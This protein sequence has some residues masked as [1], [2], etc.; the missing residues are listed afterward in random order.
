MI[1]YHNKARSLVLS[2]LLLPVL[3]AVCGI[4]EPGIMRGG[5]ASAQAVSDRVFVL[6][7]SALDIINAL[8]FGSHVVGVI[9]GRSISD[10]VYL[11]DFYDSHRVAVLELHGG[12]GTGIEIINTGGGV[13]ASANTTITN[14]VIIG[15][16]EG[17][18]D[19][20]IVRA[21]VNLDGGGNRFG[22]VAGGGF[23]LAATSE[24]GTADAA[25]VA[26]VAASI[27][28]NIASP[29][30]L[31]Q[32]HGSG[33]T[34]WADFVEAVGA[35][36]PGSTVALGANLTAA[37]MLTIDRSLTIEGNGFTI[38][39]TNAIAGAMILIHNEEE[40]IHVTF[41]NIILD[42]R[43]FSE[44][45]ARTFY[46]GGLIGSHA[47]LT[48]RNSILRNGLT[49]MITGGVGRGGAISSTGPLTIIDSRFYNNHGVRQ[50]G[51]IWASG[52][53]YVAGSVFAG[54]REERS[55][56][57]AIF[58]SGNVV[59]RDS[60]FYNNASILGSVSTGAQGGAL[61]F[62]VNNRVTIDN[63]TI[64]GN[65]VGVQVA[66]DGSTIAPN[67]LFFTIDAG[68]IIGGPG[69]LHIYHDIL[70]VVAPTLL[71]GSTRDHE[72]GVLAGVAEAARQIASVWDAED[73]AEAAI[74]DLETRF[75]AVSAA[76]N[77][78]SGIAVTL[79]APNGGFLLAPE[80][81]VS[82]SLLN[83]TGF[84]HLSLDAVPEHFRGTTPMRL[85]AEAQGGM[86][87]RDVMMLFLEWVDTQPGIDYIVVFDNVFSSLTEAEASG[88]AVD[89][90]A[91]RALNAY[92]EGRLAFFRD[93]SN[94]FG[95]T[96]M[97]MQI[98]DLEALF[99]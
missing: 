58:A 26:S 30:A 22:S 44:P 11:Q 20:D 7:H 29:P 69:Q 3:L 10:A 4:R 51:A 8:G 54:N 88:S 53:L 77:G 64:V 95:L 60:I 19:C 94:T 17:G 42:G 32:R 59:I 87:M 46:D 45:H 23:V 90:S 82:R 16:V 62:S 33:A 18:G 52:P 2:C 55:G 15:N 50:G 5:S 43:N 74:A 80:A 98:E 61:A 65:A 83:A 99:F 78:R 92:S 37:S 9:G 27:A 13:F 40:D 1:Q 39:K 68:K 6:D 86:T 67:E 81:A 72:D 28:A 25:F 63:T 66:A 21:G 34:R 71:I 97:N 84:T 47:S 70:N 36:T 14:S 96:R 75:A 91:I 38:Y 85:Y 12:A 76:A 24:Q 56:G 57:G 35:A 31:V 79:N 73:R 41:Q 89:F 48:V 93:S 49:R